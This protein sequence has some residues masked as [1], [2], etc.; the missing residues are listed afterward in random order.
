MPKRKTN[1][2]FLREV[3]GLRGD[4]YTF[5]EPYKNNRTKIIARHNKCGHF[6]NVAPKDFLNKRSG[7]PECSKKLVGEKRAK[8]PEKFREEFK[9]KFGDGYILLSDYIR[10][11]EKVRAQ[12]LVC[13]RVFESSPN[14]LIDKGSGCPTCYGNEKKSNTGFIKQIR[15][16]VGYEYDPL[17]KY[18]GGHTKIKF[19]HNACG[20]EY[21]VTPDK[22]INQ[23][24]RCPR[25]RSSKGETRIADALDRVNINYS[26]E[27]RL[28]DCRGDVHA[29]PFDFAIYGETGNLLFLIEY[30]GEQHFKVNEFFGGREQFEKRKR[31]DEIKTAYCAERGIPLVRIS[32]WQYNEIEDILEKAIR[33]YRA[34]PVGKPRERVETRWSSLTRMER[35]NTHERLAP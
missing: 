22:F 18:K 25:C 34:K 32:Y 35:Q 16:Q 1:E 27:Y 29:L 15:E 6:F 31:Y 12:H 9:Q 20:H 13:G 17:E 24:R 7:C 28:E 26:R 3:K 11:R 4:E 10:N 30:D 2:E 19:R 21:E 33:E 14:N 8:T 23:G 5:F